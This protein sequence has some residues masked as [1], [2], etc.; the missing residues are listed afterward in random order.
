M[1]VYKDRCY[2]DNGNCENMKCVRNV[3][4]IPWDELPEYMC[5][6]VRSYAGKCENYKPPKEGS[7]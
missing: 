3:K 4:N 7:A 2:C 5:V 1:I 6:S